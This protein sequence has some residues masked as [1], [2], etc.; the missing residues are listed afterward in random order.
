MGAGASKGT[1]EGLEGSSKGG[2]R[3]GEKQKN[4]PRRM[5]KGRSVKGGRK[6]RKKKKS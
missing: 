3:R 5:K 4:L 1:G 6:T 2:C